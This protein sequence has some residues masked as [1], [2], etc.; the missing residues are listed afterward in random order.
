MTILQPDRAVPDDVKQ[1]AVS[2]DGSHLA[3]IADDDVSVLKVPE[4]RVAVGHRADSGP[5]ICHTA[6]VGHAHNTKVCQ[7]RWHPLAPECLVILNGDGWLRLY[8]IGKADERGAHLRPCVAA[9][10]TPEKRDEFRQHG[11]NPVAFDFGPPSD[12]CALTIFILLENGE[13]H[14]LCPV[15]PPRTELPKRVLDDIRMASHDNTAHAWV[16]RLQQ[17]GELHI[18]TLDDTFEPPLVIGLPPLVGD[19]TP[20]LQG[21]YKILPESAAGGSFLGCVGMLSLAVLPRHAPTVLA[22]VDAQ[23]DVNVVTLLD[24]VQPCWSHGTGATRGNE[25]DAPAVWVLE[26]INL[27][28]GPVTVAEDANYAEIVID[29]TYP[30]RIYV[31]HPHGLDEIHMVYVACRSRC[32]LVA[33]RASSR[34]TVPT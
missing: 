16:D 9:K 7:V 34:S 30:S 22:T 5:K 8:D 28:F 3:L 6:T 17:A 2:I 33:L 20:L 25:A 24:Q 21:P 19:G 27:G 29:R 1:L 12:W 32:A 15:V 13:L 18:E 26:R 14:Y 31:Y 23:G 10:C 11:Y 4:P